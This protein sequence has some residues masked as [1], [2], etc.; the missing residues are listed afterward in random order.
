MNSTTFFDFLSIDLVPDNSSLLDQ[1][2]H[3]KEI[4]QPYKA[5]FWVMLGC[6]FFFIAWIIF[7]LFY[8][9]RIVGPIVSFLLTRFIRLKG[10]SG[11]ITLGSFSLSVLSGKVM[12]RSFKYICEDFSVRCNDGWIIF[13][14]WRFVSLKPIP[15]PSDTSRL[16]ISLNGLQ[17]Y[18]YNRRTVY[19]DLMKSLGFDRFLNM[20]K[21]VSGGSSIKR[22][23]SKEDERYWDLYYD[24]LWSLIGYIRLDI[25]SGRLVAGNI[26]LPSVAVLTFEN[27]ASK[28]AL[29]SFPGG[30]DRALLT[31]TA[32]VE[33]VRIS[34]IKSPG[35]EFDSHLPFVG[36]C[37]SPPRTMGDGFA[38]L[39]TAH[40]QFFYNQSILGIVKGEV[41]EL[42][43]DPPVW[44]SV[45]R[46]GKNTVISYGPWADAQR[47][48]LYN[49]FFP[50][51]HGI[52]EVTQ[53]PKNGQR[54]IL[55]AHD[56]RASLINDA[57]LDL[58]FMR[59]EEV[60][61]LNLR[62]K[63]GSS[64]DFKLPWV[65]NSEGFSSVFHCCMLFVESS[66]TLVYRKFF[67]CETLRL[68]VSADFPRIFNA[69][70]KWSYNLEINKI[71][72]W[73]AWDHKRFFTDLVCE[74][75]SDSIPDLNSFIPCTWEF[76]IKITDSF[77]LILPLN[78][79]NWI[80]SSSSANAENILA[81]I[82]GESI[83]ASFSLPFIDFTPET[84][85]LIYEI[86]VRN[87]L[88][89]R[90]WMPP[91]TVLSSLLHSLVRNSQF[92]M[93]APPCSYKKTVCG[94]FEDWVE[95]WRTEYIK[96]LFEYTYHPIY[97]DIVSDI[98]Q[99]IL[100][101]FLPERAS[102]PYEL[103]PDE[104]LIEIVIGS[105]EVLVSGY[106]I[107]FIIDLKDNYF[108]L[109]DQLTDVS[110]RDNPAM[111]YHVCG[112]EMRGVEPYRPLVTKLCL[113]LYN[114]RGHCLVPH[115]ISSEQKND[116]CPILYVEQLVVE[117]NKC[118]SETM[119]QVYLDSAAVFFEG[120]NSRNSASNTKGMLSLNVLSF[121]GHAMFSEL[122]V[123]WDAGSI[124]YAWLMEVIVGQFG[125]NITPAQALTVAQITE[126]ILLL[127][128]SPDDELELPERYDLCVH[129]TNLRTCAR[130][131][132]NLIDKR[133]RVRN[134]ETVDKVKLL[135]PTTASWTS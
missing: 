124:E 86:E 87:S 111:S 1:W 114:G 90:V 46:L 116:D 6:F 68:T 75:T 43:V 29:K 20:M 127:T 118:P 15:N 24:K 123:P 2:E 133:G 121:R 103:E 19:R 73:I 52:T 112:N 42:D 55:L 89:L 102:H 63:P 105:S 35:F 74:W 60:N 57:C 100:S 83:T 9:S 3:Y 5:S 11:H 39:Q 99:N 115:R 130:S 80:D 76:M 109:Y 128:L 41:Q 58:W 32:D 4:V 84:V 92:K 134:C 125:G 110:S 98:P 81:A 85:N 117:L 59:D 66:T 7:L 131:P 70:Q 64:F 16:H 21:E 37:D 94:S 95:I 53:M 107:R 77:E 61:A 51:H 18:L 108:G 40:L 93:R 54:R 113:R 27:Y 91:Q 78:D 69:A 44:E 48:L 31:V 8:L 12:F 132:L 97:C 119:I 22:L 82:S 135:L 36:R 38:V 72:A 129:M 13:S 50:P 122:D 106:M 25:G 23:A 120:M 49:F 14:Y 34:L 26:T 67:E 30:A 10:Y 45:W 104:L 71:R 96:L 79:K 33:N 17:I 28:V 101:H 47:V 56:C 126:S 88:A 65:I 62:M